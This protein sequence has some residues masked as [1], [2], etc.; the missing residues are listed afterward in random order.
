MTHTH[1]R[2]PQK[3]ACL[4]AAGEQTA[5]NGVFRRCHVGF[6]LKEEEGERSEGKSMQEQGGYLFFNGNLLHKLQ[7]HAKPTACLITDWANYIQRR[8][9]MLANKLK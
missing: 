1:T 7:M 4:A 9:E 8:L 2:H 3:Q 5:R 6:N